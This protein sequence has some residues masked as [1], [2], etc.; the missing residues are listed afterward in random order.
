M[1]NILIEF[2]ILM[3]LVRLIKI[4]VNETYRK[5]HA[6]KNLYDTVPIKNGLKR[7]DNLSPL[8]VY[9]ALKYD[10]RKVQTNQEGL[11]LNGT[12]Q[13]LVYIDD[14]NLLGVNKAIT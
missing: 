13:C 10:S 6:D 5:V 11:K 8:L 4:Y 12:H 7:G 9:L 3:K 2:G 1:Y 14:G